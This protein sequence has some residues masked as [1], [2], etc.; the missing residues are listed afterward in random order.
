MTLIGIEFP[1]ILSVFGPLNR[2][3][4]PENCNKIAVR[5][6]GTRKHHVV[7]RAEPRKWVHLA[8]FC[9]SKA[10]NARAEMVVSRNHVLG[11][12]CVSFVYCQMLGP[13]LRNKSMFVKGMAIP[14]DDNGEERPQLVEGVYQCDRNGRIR[15]LVGN[16]TDNHGGLPKGQKFSC[17][18]LKETYLKVSKD[19][20]ARGVIQ[21][22]SATEGGS[23]VTEDDI[24]ANGNVNVSC[25]SA[26]AVI[27]WDLSKAVFSY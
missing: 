20:L 22:V 12:N 24:D 16:M 23:E 10:S 5:L 18:I 4:T 9:P 8:A 15:L 11:A 26:D 13:N 2:P 1:M 14:G 17:A 7:V 3:E 19:Q 6:G 21:E 25:F 27:W